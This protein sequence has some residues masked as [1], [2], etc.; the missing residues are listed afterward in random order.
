[1]KLEKWALIAEVISGVGVLI[2]LI[3]LVVGMRENAAVN[4]LIAYNGIMDSRAQHRRSF[5]ENEELGQLGMS[6]ARDP[7]EFSEVENYRRYNMIAGILE[8]D[9]KA[10]FAHQIGVLGDSAWAHIIG[11][12]CFFFDAAETGL[13]A[14]GQTGLKGSLTEEFFEFLQQNC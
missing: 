6:L 3:L 4:R 1:M 11:D 8:T 2:T 10:Y 12:A 14:Q 5:I 9:E 13:T 7:S